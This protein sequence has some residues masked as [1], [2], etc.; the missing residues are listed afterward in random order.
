MA[1]PDKQ[2][3]LDL[4]I[5][6]L[7]IRF[8]ENT[9]AKVYVNEQE[10]FT[11]LY[12]GEEAV[13]AGVCAN[14]R[15]DDY[16]TSTHR[17]HGHVIAKG[18][19]LKKMMA[20][21]YGRV[22]GYCKGKSGSLHIADFSSGVL[23]ANGIVAAGIPIANG[24]AYSAKYRQTD[25]VAVAFFGDGATTQGAFHEAVNMG[26]IWDL[27][28]VYVI[29]NNMYLVGTR[30][31]RVCKVCD[32]LS[33][34]AKGY[35]I[36]GVDIDGNDVLKVYEASKKAI[37]KARDGKGPTLINCLT[38]RH[39]THFEGDIDTRQEKEVKDWLSKD[40]IKRFESYLIDNDVTS[41][42]KIQG[43]KKDVQTQVDEAVDFAR[44]SPRPT[45]GS[46]IQDVYTDLD[47]AYSEAE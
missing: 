22:D 38:Y 41:E 20:E 31:N 12:I 1:G 2:T 7:K 19:D 29:E 14:L 37:K 47:Q 36:E 3:L 39:H 35:G 32:K 11:H 28:V 46:A 40:P 5:T 10:G 34:K 23:G 16:I 33:L 43:L 30:F 27:P 24:A 45:P 42:E 9:Q 44:K 13:A 6:M 15:K 21:L 17:G 26:A 25:Q 4:Y 18:G 8:F